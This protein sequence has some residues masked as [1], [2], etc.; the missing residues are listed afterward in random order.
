VIL[1]VG[2]AQRKVIVTPVGRGVT[3]IYHGKSPLH[4]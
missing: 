1:L 4:A 3:L 2:S